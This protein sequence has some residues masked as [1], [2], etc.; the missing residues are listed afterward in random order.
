M[1]KITYYILLINILFA[2]DKMISFFGEPGHTYEMENS[3][4]KF[5]MYCDEGGRAIVILEDKDGNKV[6]GNYF[7]YKDINSNIL[8]SPMQISE[9]VDSKNL[10]LFR[11][12]IKN[13]YNSTEIK[14][15]NDKKQEVGNFRDWK[16]PKWE[17]FNIENYNGMI[18]FCSM[19]P[20]AQE[21]SI[22]TSV[23]PQNPSGTVT[24]NTIKISSSKYKLSIL[25]DS[26]NTMPD[27]NYE[28][29]IF[30]TETLN[31]D[32]PFDIF[33]DNK[34]FNIPKATRNTNQ[35]SEKEISNFNDFIQ[36]LVDAKTLTVKNTTFDISNR[37]N[38][39][40]SNAL[41]WCKI[42]T[43]KFKSANFDQNMWEFA[44]ELDQNLF[45][46]KNKNLEMVIY[47]GTG[48]FI[49]FNNKN[50]NV[51]IKISKIKIDGKDTLITMPYSFDS[52]KMNY[53]DFDRANIDF[54]KVFKQYL[55]VVYKILNAKNIVI[56]NEN[57]KEIINYE[58]LNSSFIINKF[59]QML[60]NYNIS[61]D[62]LLA[63]A[64][65]NSNSP[66]IIK[67]GDIEKENLPFYK[68]IFEKV[69]KSYLIA[70]EFI[71]SLF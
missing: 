33:V 6:E 59:E 44:K 7:Y 39:N 40:I 63:I 53:T 12:F 68:K 36:S 19:Y 35:L 43:F 13:L 22:T 11:N 71:R 69:K 48:D 55:A 61:K 9:G 34:K 3:N 45:F 25:C 26:G 10:E 42:K 14:F 66:K 38:F 37:E 2:N 50:G 60:K 16:D 54:D 41:N 46:I 49:L 56:Y 18:R 20:P 70:F 24:A 1:K 15:Y 30:S 57:D 29:D 32:N 4:G 51:D 65:N 58:P 27:I 47:V 21:A 28:T 52:F 31:L 8:K 62:E 17:D 23:E 67:N 64:T 5:T